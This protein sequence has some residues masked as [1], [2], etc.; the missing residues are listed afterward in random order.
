MDMDLGFDSIS[1]FF[2]QKADGEYIIP[3]QPGAVEEFYKRLEKEG[4]NLEE[5]KDILECEDN[6]LIVSAAGAGK[7][8][9][10]ILKILRD[11]VAGKL[12]REVEF[13]GKTVYVLKKVL[14]CTFLKTGAKDIADK[15]DE[16]VKKLKIKNISSKKKEFKFSTIDSEVYAALRE[17]TKLPNG[18]TLK[19]T[20]GEEHQ[21]NSCLREACNYYKIRSNSSKSYSKRMT[22]EELGDISCLLSYTRSR[23]D[24]LRFSHPI[25]PEY[26]LGEIELK[27]IIEQYNQNKIAKGIQD[28]GDLE[29]ALYD[30]IKKSPKAVEFLKNR[31]DYVYIDEFQDTSQLQYAILEPY[32]K[33]AERMLILGDE[34]QCLQGNVE[35]T[36]ENGVK[37]I[38]EIVEGEKVLSCIGKN[39]VKFMPV[40]KVFKKKI[41]EEIVIVKTKSGK[42][43]KGTKD[44]IVFTKLVPEENITNVYLMYCKDIGFRI[45]TTIS[46]RH[47]NKGME[48]CGITQR[49][50]REKGD[51]VWILKRCNSYEDARYWETFLSYKYSIPQY[52]FKLEKTKTYSP[53]FSDEMLLKLHKNLDTM[54][55]GFRLLQDYGYNFDYP[56]F[57]P[58]GKN[59]K[60]VLNLKLLGGN[61]KNV[62]DIWTSELS[63]DTQ[64]EDYLNSFLGS[65]NTIKRKASG[66]RNEYYTGRYRTNDVDSL[67]DKIKEIESACKDNNV[68]L[69]VNKEIKLSDSSYNFMPL[70]NVIEGMTI[71]IYDGKNIIEDEVISVSFEMLDDYVYDLSVPMTRN[72]IANSFVVKNCIYSWRGSD[73]DLILNRVEKDYN[74]T[75]KKLS[76]NR[77]CAKT[78]LNAVVPSI[79]QNTL[80]HDKELKASKDGGEID[81]VIDGGV[82]SFSNYIKE[83]ML[84]GRTVGVLGR[85][86]ADLIVPAMVLLVEGYKSFSIPKQCKL[87]DGAAQNIIGVLTLLTKQHT[88]DF[89]RLLKLFLKKN[90]EWQATKLCDVLSTSRDYTLFNLPLEDI[91]YSAPDLFY[92]IR[93]IRR[94]CS[95]NPYTKAIEGDP[96][97]AYI[98]LLDIMQEDVYN[99]NSIYAQRAR[100]LCYYIK[101]LL[102]E[103]EKFKNMDIFELETLFIYQYPKLFE[104]RQPKKPIRKKDS[105]GRWHDEEVT[106][107]KVHIELKTVHDAKGKEWDN[108]YIWNNVNGCFPNSVGNREL[109]DGEFEEERRVHYIAWTRPK[110][111]LVVFTRS[112]VDGGFLEEC[113]LTEA[114]IIKKNEIVTGIQN[115]RNASVSS[116]LQNKKPKTFQ[117]LKPDTEKVMRDYILKYTDYKKICTNEGVNLDK[118]IMKMGNTD[119]LIEYMKTQGLEK[120]PKDMLES[121]ISLIIESYLMTNE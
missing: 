79:E 60:C 51:K 1:N 94:Y 29:D 59:D 87:T 111:K 90:N 18:A 70:C 4:F 52:M 77:R 95:V 68:N 83:D 22:E 3:G 104:E 96:V 80:R 21:L 88:N 81:I 33:G 6:L 45:G 71:A 50:R 93:G 105:L 63:C 62:D 120:Y 97:K 43:L 101:K 26:N 28:F 106:Q 5:L 17:G 110:K 102:L 32:L 82:Q 115:I 108:V 25:M 30:H 39:K 9:T 58:K 23:L 113:D 38:S 98:Y 92:V 117:D 100:D 7:T 76:V 27:G 116:L 47:K 119:K 41:N 36:T 69:Y 85:T 10:L 35:I 8:T 75:V 13:E 109:T 20:I 53:V 118:I 24:N 12:L 74:P 44:H 57:V 64:N 34:D 16:F 15:F 121:S 14:V 48:V 56:H 78:I 31:Y 67:F 114:K 107:E 103:H 54:S 42:E 11:I 91:Q 89:E 37:K 61:Y 49:L 65:L 72:F 2:N 19:I 40:N 86:N 99:T 46:K 73:I 55:N 66:G 112:D 84:Q